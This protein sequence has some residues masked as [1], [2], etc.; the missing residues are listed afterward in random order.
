MWLFDRVSFVPRVAVALFVCDFFGVRVFCVNYLF[1]LPSQASEDDYAPIDPKSMDI[2]QRMM[3]GVL[4]CN[5]VNAIENSCSKSFVKF[6]RI[7]TWR[8]RSL[9]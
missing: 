5:L 7:F 1:R 8:R 3:D 4:L 6:V 9:R 2:F